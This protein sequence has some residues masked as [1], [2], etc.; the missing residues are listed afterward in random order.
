MLQ[1][2]RTLKAWCGDYGPCTIIMHPYGYRSIVDNSVR[3]R[4]QLNHANIIVAE[5]G[6][7]MYGHEHTQQHGI[8]HT[9]TTTQGHGDVGETRE[10][11]GT[12]V[13]GDRTMGDPATE[14]QGHR[15]RTQPRQDL[16]IGTDLFASA[17]ENR[18]TSCIANTTQNG[19]PPSPP[20]HHTLATTPTTPPTPQQHRHQQWRNTHIHATTIEGSPG[21]HTT[22]QKRRL[23][24]CV[25]CVMCQQT[26]YR[27]GGGRPW[28]PPSPQLRGRVRRGTSPGPEPLD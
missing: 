13:G 10:W 6:L 16:E 23:G 2:V 21:Q 28:T 27:V 22:A 24:H 25:P 9:T 5:V 4:A 3:L 8:P 11:W 20:P 19:Q 12:D 18:I 26:F 1:L 7:R 15:W 14:G 17:A